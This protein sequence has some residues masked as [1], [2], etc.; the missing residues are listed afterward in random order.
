MVAQF[1]HFCWYI[2]LRSREEFLYRG[3]ELSLCVACKVFLSVVCQCP[4]GSR[5]SRGVN[6]EQ[7]EVV[8]S[9]IFLVCGQFWHY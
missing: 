6:Q 4:R 1:S 9:E 5:G 7:D 3:V 8:T 2:I